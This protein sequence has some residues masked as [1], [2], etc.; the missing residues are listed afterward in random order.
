[1]C[2]HREIWFQSYRPAMKTMF[3]VLN[4]QNVQMPSIYETKSRYFPPANDGNLS[5]RC[6]IQTSKVKKKEVTNESGS[7]TL[8][9]YPSHQPTF[10]GYTWPFLFCL[11]ISKHIRAL[12]SSPAV[13]FPVGF[14]ELDRTVSRT[15]S[16][17]N[18]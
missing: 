9:V 18:V 8:L 1:M 6:Y 13:P 5:A 11:S 15:G 2:S 14:V 3:I 4:N 7:G 10:L 16:R 12:I 17:G